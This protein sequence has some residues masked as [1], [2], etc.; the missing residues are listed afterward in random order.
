MHLP[1]SKIWVPGS[2][3]GTPCRS[4][5]PEKRTAAQQ[6][7]DERY[8]REQDLWRMAAVYMST[9]MTAF[10]FSENGRNSEMSTSVNSA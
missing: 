7:G 3:A 5:D 9:R 8:D 1:C 4:S 2:A 10:E 6:C